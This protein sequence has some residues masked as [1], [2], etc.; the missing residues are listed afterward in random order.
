MSVIS[1]LVNN[2]TTSSSSSYFSSLLGSSSTSTSSLGLTD[3]AMI[4]S[5]A[6]YKLMKAYYAEEDSTSTSL[7][8]EDEK[9]YTTAK[10]AAED[11]AQSTA[12]LMSSDFS[13]DN[14]EDLLAS[15]K[16][17]VEDYNSLIESTDDVDDTATLRQVLWL[18]QSTSA[19]EN[20]LS[21]IG[22]TVNSDNTL[23]LDEDT[24]E[25]ADLTTLQTLFSRSQTSSYGNNVISKAAATYNAAASVISG[26]STGSAYT[27]S[28][29]YAN[30]LSASSLFDT[31]T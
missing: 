30:T 23:S 6:Y 7:S 9:S 19:N 11:L 12:S 29:Q 10:S 17:W 1:S 18:T 27:A 22:I 28:A 20:L 26:T 13:E 24:F 31:T 2:S 16:S 4:K 15:L 21:K 5:G 3:Y 25:D 8:E 14:R